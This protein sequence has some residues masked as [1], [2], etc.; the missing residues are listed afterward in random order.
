MFY[1]EP[2]ELRMRVYCLFT[3]QTLVAQHQEL[4][5]LQHLS[6]QRVLHYKSFLTMTSYL[7]CQLVHF[8]VHVDPEW[9]RP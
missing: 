3:M 7:L 1:S 8:S 6:R 2:G 4:L 9:L 5:T